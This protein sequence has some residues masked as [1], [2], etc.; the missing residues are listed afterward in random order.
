MATSTLQS[1]GKAATATMTQS[2]SQPAIHPFS[3]HATDADLED[4]R[5]RT[6]QFLKGRNMDVVVHVEREG[7][8]SCW[9]GG[10]N[11]VS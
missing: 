6:I 5:E 1:N 9:C 2:A 8:G 7:D 4:V 11:K 10:G 3:F